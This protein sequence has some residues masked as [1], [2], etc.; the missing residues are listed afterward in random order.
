VHRPRPPACRLRANN[1]RGGGGGKVRNTGARERNLSIAITQNQ[2]SCGGNSCKSEAEVAVCNAI[3]WFECQT[4]L[5]VQ[6]VRSDRG[7]EYMGN[8]L[9]RFYEKKGIQ[10]EQGPGY[11]PETSR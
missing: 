8:D 6:R 10:R 4:D 5:R 9:L 1:R 7:E 11:S 3:A 2:S